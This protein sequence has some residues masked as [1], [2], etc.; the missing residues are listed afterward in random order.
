ME[1]FTA[2]LKYERVKIFK[3]DNYGSWNTRRPEV[4]THF[5]YQFPVLSIDSV[6]IDQQIKTGIMSFKAKISLDPFF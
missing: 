3:V 6:R 5:V 4:G 2:Y 1:G